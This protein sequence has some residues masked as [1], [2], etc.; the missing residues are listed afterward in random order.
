M[1]ERNKATALAFDYGARR[2]GC[3]VAHAETQTTHAVATLTCKN[4][5]DATAQSL[6]QIGQAQPDLVLV[7]APTRDDGT[8]SDVAEAAMRFALRIQARCPVPVFLVNEAYSTASASSKLAQ[9]GVKGRKQKGL[10]DAYA[11]AEIGQAWLDSPGFLTPVL[12]HDKLDA[13]KKRFLGEEGLAAPD[14]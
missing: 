10:V 6:A 12:A 5:D 11:A 2:I 8:L 14:D 4:K 1:T 7:G 9:A 13:L 3:A